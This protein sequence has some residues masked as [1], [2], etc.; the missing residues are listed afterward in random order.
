MNAEQAAKRWDRDPT[1]IRE[2][3]RRGMIPGAEKLKR[4][5]S[6]PAYDSPPVS[7]P[8]RDK[9]SEEDRREI[10]RQGHGGANRTKL[11]QAYGVKRLH[12]YHLMK[13][14]PPEK[15]G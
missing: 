13:K 11:A 1:I 7:L 6:I 15:D 14:Y 9:L 8:R 12:V 2:F 5:W 4:D 3:C 10:A